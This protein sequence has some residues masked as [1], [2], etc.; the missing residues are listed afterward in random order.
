VFC[1]KIYI[2]LN[3]FEAKATFFWIVEVFTADPML[4]LLRGIKNPPV[5]GGFK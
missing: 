4:F 3:K 1:R 2:A 5:E